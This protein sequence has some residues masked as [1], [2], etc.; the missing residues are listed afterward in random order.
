MLLPTINKNAPSTIRSTPMS[1]ATKT[2]CDAAN[3]ASITI[4]IPNKKLNTERIVYFLSVRYIIPS[5]P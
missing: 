3:T 4:K 2:G 1:I 5:N